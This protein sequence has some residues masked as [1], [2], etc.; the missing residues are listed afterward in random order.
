MFFIIKVEIEK[1]TGVRLC[2]KK[3]SRQGAS[4]KVQ[5]LI[6]TTENPGSA[7]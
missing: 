5:P 7:L 4:L 2:L 1:L 3:Y 6:M